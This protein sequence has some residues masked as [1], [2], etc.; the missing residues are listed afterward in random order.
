[1]C[2]VRNGQYMNKQR[3]IRLNTALGLCLWLVVLSASAFYN[4]TAGKWLSRDPIGEAAFRLASSLFEARAVDVVANN[5]VVNAV[6]FLGLDIIAKPI[7]TNTLTTTNSTL[8]ARSCS[9]QGG[10]YYM[11]CSFWVKPGVFTDVL[12]LRGCL[13]RA[14]HLFNLGCATQC[15]FASQGRI[16]AAF[17]KCYDRYGP[18]VDRTKAAPVPVPANLTGVDAAPESLWPPGF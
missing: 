1:M 2:W 14:I 11:Y 16:C 9:S 13:G 15:S 7:G 8:F 12:G 10:S 18:G 6:D 17:E 5:D 4:P 3:I